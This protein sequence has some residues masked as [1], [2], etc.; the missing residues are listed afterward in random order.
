MPII[1]GVI[2]L[3]ASLTAQANIGDMLSIDIAYV[4]SLPDPVKPWGEQ[5]PH[6]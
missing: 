5:P 1:Y 4:A 6:E 2:A 3:N